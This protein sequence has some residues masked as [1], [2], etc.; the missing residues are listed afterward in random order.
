[1]VGKSKKAKMPKNVIHVLILIAGT[2]DPVNSATHTSIN[3][4]SYGTTPQNLTQ[5]QIDSLMNVPFN[6]WDKEFKEQVEKFDEDYENLVLFPFYGWSG[7]NSKENRE[8]AGKYLVNRLYTK[9]KYNKQG[10]YEGWNKK[11]VYFHLLGHSHGGNVINEMTKQI[12][13]LGD[14]WPEKWKIKSITYLSTPFFKKL[15]QVKVNEKVFHKDA[16]IISLYNDFDLTQRMLADF[17]L[18]TLSGALLRLDTKKLEIYINDFKTY[19][20]SFPIN[21]LTGGFSKLKTIISPAWGAYD[22]N[23]MTYEDGL[24][25]YDF[26]IKNLLLA[27]KNILEE[28]IKIIDTL[29]QAKTYEVSHKDL[30]KIIDKKEHTIIPKSAAIQM[31]SFIKILDADIDKIIKDLKDVIE[32]N[33]KKE[34]FSKLTYLEILFKDNQL[35]PHLVEFLDIN[36]NTLQGVNTSLWNQLYEILNHNI[37]DFDNTYV[38]PDTQYKDSFLKDKI[39]NINISND[40]IYSSKKEA[41]NYYKFIKYIENIE[42]RYEAS[43]TQFNL[44]DLLFTLVFQEKKAKD[45]IETVVNIISYID[46]AEYIATGEVDVRLK[47]LKGLLTNI[48]TVF[49]IR[50]FGELEDSTHKITPQQEKDNKD[51]NPYNDTLKRGSLMYLLTQSH[52]TSRRR[53]HPKVKEFLQ[54]LGAVR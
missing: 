27:L 52:S 22:Y 38:K 17:S 36:P 49:N 28:S 20:N 33:T 24:E 39:T 2:T 4:R 43:P 7:D 32:A 5:E 10:Y 40:D 31:K 6:Y 1:M 53:L 23:Q 29:S 47:L 18:E 13:K 19:L 9:D 42:E 12:D 8:I 25:L 46:T 48:N 45:M 21:I 37:A 50:N 26:T 16:E 14:K 34:E 11:P 35:I 41:L 54:R 15:H 44:L 30:K 51:K 3:A